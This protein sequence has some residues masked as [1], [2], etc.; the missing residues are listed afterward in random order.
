MRVR[1]EI[2]ARG[3]L[4]RSSNR[5]CKRTR[6]SRRWHRKYLRARRRPWPVGADGPS[7]K[8]AKPSRTPKPA[9]GLGIWQTASIATRR[10]ESGRRGGVWGG[11]GGGGGDPY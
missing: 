11:G 9:D 8:P 10:P 7:K 5:A 6:P 2:V 3:C 1:R 4:R